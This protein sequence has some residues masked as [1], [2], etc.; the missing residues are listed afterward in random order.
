MKRERYQDTKENQKEL[1]RKKHSIDVGVTSFLFILVLFTLTQLFALDRIETVGKNGEFV[2]SFEGFGILPFFL[3]LFSADVGITVVG[4]ITA[5]LG[6][7][8][9]MMGFRTFGAYLAVLPILIVSLFA[10]ITPLTF[11]PYVMSGTNPKMEAFLEYEGVEYSDFTIEEV[12]PDDVSVLKN[13]LDAD[14]GVKF[15]KEG[16]FALVQ[17]KG[18]GMSVYSIADKMDK[19]D[20]YALLGTVDGKDQLQMKSFFNGLG[21]K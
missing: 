15:P 11:M 18:D 8:T 17:E 1:E 10:I 3:N 16:K 4:G 19:V 9:I 21:E 12:G 7:A 20:D 14:E 6:A 13:S 5:G 2:S